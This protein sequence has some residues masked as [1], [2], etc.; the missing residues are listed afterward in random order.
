MRYAAPKLVIMLHKGFIIHL[1]LKFCQTS[2]LCFGH[3]NLFQ[4]CLLSI[5]PKYIYLGKYLK[6]LANSNVIFL[7]AALNSI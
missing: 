7:K 5:E 2:L 4:H 3:Q 1:Y 6:F